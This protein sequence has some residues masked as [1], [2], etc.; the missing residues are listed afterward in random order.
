MSGTK[1][2]SSSEAELMRDLIAALDE[3]KDDI[4]SL[5][6]DVNHLSNELKNVHVT[7]D[8]KLTDGRDME[9]LLDALDSRTSFNESIINKLIEIKSPTQEYPSYTQ[10]S[11]PITISE[12]EKEENLTPVERYKLRKKKNGGLPLPD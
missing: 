7:V 1:K 2:S 8:A 9:H 11:Y 4:Q 12:K 3:I 6:E 5:R 10:N